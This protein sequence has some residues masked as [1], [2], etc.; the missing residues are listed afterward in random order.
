MPAKV[1]EYLAHRRSLGYALK[2]EGLLLAGF[3]RYAERI[4]HRGPLTLELAL[5]WARQPARAHPTYWARRLGVVRGL[6]KYLRLREPS[7]EVPDT[8]LLRPV[9]RRKTP[10]IYSHEEVLQLLKNAGRGS[11]RKG[12]P[13]R[14]ISTVIGLLAVTGMRISEVLNLQCNDVDWNHRV[15]TVR[16]AKFH[17]ARLIPLHAT[18]VAKLAQYAQER[19][20]WFPKARSF[21]VSR[22]GTPL[23]YGTVQHIFHQLVK[24][25]TPRGAYPRPRLHDLRHAFAC[26]TLTRWSKRPVTMDQRMLFLMHYLGH[27]Q[28]RHTYWYLSAIPELLAR[29]AAHFEH[30]TNA[31]DP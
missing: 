12:L 20:R 9:C 17:K 7:T 11:R 24:G 28:I 3:A 16:E 30:Y 6:A 27:T 19:H 8:R 23:S 2:A 14:T 21:F 18:T 13:S 1:A 10:H 31:F 29:A 5:C 25:I 4:G 22:R 26:R 15:I